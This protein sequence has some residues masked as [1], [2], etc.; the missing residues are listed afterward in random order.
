MRMRNAQKHAVKP[1][2]R[3]SS[4][5]TDVSDLPDFEPLSDS[6]DDYEKLDDKFE[7]ELENEFSLRKR[8]KMTDSNVTHDKLSLIVHLPTP[9][10]ERTNSSVRHPQLAPLAPDHPLLRSS[11]D[12]D[13]LRSTSADAT[14]SRMPAIITSCNAPPS[15]SAAVNLLAMSG[16]FVVHDAPPSATAEAEQLIVSAS[17]DAD[18]EPQ[19][20]LP[21]LFDADD[22]ASALEAEAHDGGPGST[23]IA[24]TGATV[25]GVVGF[26]LGQVASGYL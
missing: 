25:A 19:T 24:A 22:L 9:R 18:G 5:L 12:H 6:D 20:T 26:M 16:S 10:S 15:T 8:R 13:D 2:R 21:G 4:P 11:S 3:L 17:P 14:P 23:V 1:R 7:V